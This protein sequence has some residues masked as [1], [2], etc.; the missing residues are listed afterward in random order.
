VGQLALDTKAIEKPTRTP[1]HNPNADRAEVS[2]RVS[3]ATKLN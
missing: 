2:A 3:H 1:A